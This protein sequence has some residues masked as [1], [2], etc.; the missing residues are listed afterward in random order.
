MLDRILRMTFSSLG[1]ARACRRLGQKAL[2]ASAVIGAASLGG[3][4]QKG[5]LTLPAAAPAASAASG[6]AR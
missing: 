6:A 2:L 3:C 5:P 1:L 4:G